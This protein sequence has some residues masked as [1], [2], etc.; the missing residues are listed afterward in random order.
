MTE[1][2]YLIPNSDGTYYAQVSCRKPAE[3]AIYLVDEGTYPTQILARREYSYG[4]KV[5]DVHY[6]RNRTE[7][8]TSLNWMG[9]TLCAVYQIWEYD[10]AKCLENDIINLFENCT[11]KRQEL[12]EET[13]MI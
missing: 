9:K 5:W 7:M 1:K 2:V 6:V 10:I 12:L 11:S 4:Y 8:L 3:N 13:E